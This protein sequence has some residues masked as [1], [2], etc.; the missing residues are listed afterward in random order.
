M[1]GINGVCVCMWVG[2]GRV[3]MCKEGVSVVVRMQQV[4][5]F[6]IDV[7]A[8]TRFH[9]HVHTY[10]QTDDKTDSNRQC[11]RARVQSYYFSFFF[12][13]VFLLIFFFP[14]GVLCTILLPPPPPNPARLSWSVMTTGPSDGPH[15]SI[16][17]YAYGPSSR[18]HPSI[19]P[20]IHT[21]MG[22]LDHTHPSIHP[23]ACGPSSRPHPHPSIHAG[24]GS[25]SQDRHPQQW[26]QP[27]CQQRLGRHL[28]LWCGCGCV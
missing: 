26:R 7:G 19:H 2:W 14:F 10:I 20:S 4:L 5:S 15:P 22:C 3:G 9:T 21:P 12:G 28:P 18:P 8:K 27:P 13:G 25:V 1:C 11:M 24:S 16:H 17:P 23:Y 6:D